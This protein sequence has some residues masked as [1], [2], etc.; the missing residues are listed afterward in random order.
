MRVRSTVRWRVALDSR[1][2]PLRAKLSESGAALK[3]ALGMAVRTPPMEVMAAPMAVMARLITT[4]VGEPR[5]I[6]A[7]CWEHRAR[8]ERCGSGHKPGPG[9]EAIGGG[10]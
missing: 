1:G 4:C 3:A 2:V 5:G 8:R 7:S 6:R 10:R 9:C